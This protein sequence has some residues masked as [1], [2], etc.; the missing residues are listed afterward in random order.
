MKRYAIAF[1]RQGEMIKCEVM[2]RPIPDD[3]DVVCLGVASVPD[4]V[5]LWAENEDDAR[6]RA[7]QLW[8]EERHVAD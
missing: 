5:D 7:Y 6:E 3:P 4:W 2:K 8:Q 1:T